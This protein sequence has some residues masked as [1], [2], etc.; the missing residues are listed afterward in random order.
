M[1]ELRK[2]PIIDR[3]VIIA[4]ERGKRPVNYKL[5]SRSLNQHQCPFCPGNEHM[6]PPEIHRLNESSEWRMRVIP[7]KYPA[8]HPDVNPCEH[9]G[10]LHQCISGIGK[11]EVIIETNK[12]DQKMQQF[13]LS[14]MNDV[15]WLYKKRYQEIS[16]ITSMAYV[17]IFKNEGEKAGA[18]IDHAH[19]QIIALPVIPRV[20]AEELEK[21]E[22]HFKSTEKCIFCELI[23]RESLLEERLIYNNG[24]FIAIEPYAAR[25]P[26]ETWILPLGHESRFEFM[27]PADMKSLSEAMIEV[28]QRLSCCI[29]Q[30][31]YNIVIHNA[32]VSNVYDRYFHWHIEIIPKLTKVAGFE[33]GSGFY[34]NPTPPEEAAEF[35]RSAEI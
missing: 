34:I 2:D 35:M 14:R 3:W 32:P 13:D 19:S 10:L 8:V 7:N 25:F 24:H 12:H 31:S 28:L 15:L 27:K 16:K 6:T 18:T 17:M 20:I 26:F 22:Q 1:S 23:Y 5:T 11:H 33:W 29:D 30:F 4:K 21:S 9:L